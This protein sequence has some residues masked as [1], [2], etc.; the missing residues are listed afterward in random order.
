MAEIEQPIVIK[1]IKKGGHGHH[2]GAW[3]VAYADFVTAMMAFFLL[4]WLLNATTQVQKMGL[5][6][7]FTPTVGLKDSMGI[8]FKGGLKQAEAGRSK[9][10]LTKV[11]LVVGQTKQGP[12]P[13]APTQA[14]GEPKENAES[15]SEAAAK[16]SESSEDSETFSSTSEEIKQALQE[17]EELKEYQNNIVVQDTPEGLKIDVID[18]PK[19]PMFV[20]GGAV[21]TDTGKKIL[22]S[23]ASMI[24]KTPNNIT[25]NGHTDAASATQNPQYSIW[26][27]SADRALSA[28]RFLG[29]TQLEPERVTKIV[30]LADKEL[31]VPQEPTSPR[32]R[33][34]TIL[35]QRGSYLRDPKLAPTTRTLLSVPDTKLKKDEPKQEQAPQAPVNTAPA[36][37][38]IFNP[39]NIVPPDAEAAPS[40]ETK[41]E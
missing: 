8:G 10:D 12:Q 27:L 4:L 36:A 21:L 26:E 9:S 30:A 34:I 39:A 15:E 29:S 5:A 2:G 31:L 20:P 28:R 6:E 17:D 33:R 11:G 13:G 16:A 38:S 3:K 40:T 19:K 23:M 32:N 7:Y 37:D 22:D 41:P 1:R 35:L 18:D 25:I 14:E 24:I